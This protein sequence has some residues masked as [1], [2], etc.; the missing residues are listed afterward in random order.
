MSTSWLICLY[1]SYWPSLRCLPAGSYACI[2]YQQE[3]IAHPSHIS[4]QYLQHI[5]QSSIEKSKI[6]MKQSTSWSSWLIC[7]CRLSIRTYW[8]P[9]VHVYYLYLLHFYHP[10]MKKSNIWMI[11]RTAAFMNKTKIL[12]THIK[13]LFSV[14]IHNIIIIDHPSMKIVFNFT[15]AH[16]SVNNIFLMVT[17]HIVLLPA[18]TT[19][20]LLPLN[21]QNI[22]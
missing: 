9:L 16:M 7:L 11:K 14:F 6:L 18:L 5:D 22:W 12:T 8:P 19:Y 3:H 4:L 17:P 21:K 1:R 13:F 10:S 15:L 20:L 2:N